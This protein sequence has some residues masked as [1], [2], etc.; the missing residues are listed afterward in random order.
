MNKLLNLFFLM[1]FSVFL[2]YWFQNIIKK[3]KKYMYVPFSSE[4]N[5]PENTEENI[6]EEN[7]EEENTEGNTVILNNT[8]QY[9]N[10]GNIIERNSIF[11]NWDNYL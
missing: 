9:I 1:I 8:P 7:I 10:I 6:E 2:F 5:I 4:L 11:E 3:K